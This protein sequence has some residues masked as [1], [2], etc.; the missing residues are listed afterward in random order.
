MV[1]V[2]VFELCYSDVDAGAV[3]LREC[4]TPGQIR[5]WMELLFPPVRHRPACLLSH[6]PYCHLRLLILLCFRSVSSFFRFGCKLSGG[7][8]L[9][10]ITGSS[11]ASGVRGKLGSSSHRNESIRVPR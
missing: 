9:D 8:H 11:V 4:G 1:L 7:G 3:G 2:S 5:R 10:G 6:S